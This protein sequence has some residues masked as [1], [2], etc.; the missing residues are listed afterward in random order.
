MEIVN[1]NNLSISEFQDANELN[2]EE[3]EEVTGGGLMGVFAGG[4][5]GGAAG[6]A[7]YAGTW[8][9]DSLMGRSKGFDIH[10]MNKSGVDGAVKGAVVGG[11]VSLLL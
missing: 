3:L 8:G 11:L 2:A 1:E 9:Y 7:S 6:M 10:E 4:V 5:F